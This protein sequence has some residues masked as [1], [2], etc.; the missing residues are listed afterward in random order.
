MD[1]RETKRGYCEW[2]DCPDRDEKTDLYY[3]WYCKA[4]LCDGCLEHAEA[5]REYQ[6]E[7]RAFHG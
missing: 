5:I 1:Y 2:E 7:L 3:D 4:W 6:Q